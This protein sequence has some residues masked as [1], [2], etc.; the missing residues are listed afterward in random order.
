MSLFV[1]VHSPLC[2][3][4][5]WHSTAQA[6]R[7]LGHDA[8]VLSFTSD[9]TNPAPLWQQQAQIIA[10]QLR[11]LD[12]QQPL[13]W[14]GHS[15][16]GLRLPVYRNAVANPATGYVFVDAGVPYDFPSEGMSQLDAMRRE[17]SGFAEG[18]REFLIN[19]GRFPNW[20][21]EML[22]DDIPNDNVRAM[23]LRELQPQGLRYFD[24]PIPMPAKWPDAPCAYLHFSQSY[25]ADATYAI[26]HQWAHQKIEAGHFQML[27]DPIGTARAIV[28]LK[29][30]I[31]ND[32]QLL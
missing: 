25:N 30:E 8:I 27:I 1:M 2:G 10:E 12:A 18:L 16:A 20:T 14:V 3:P 28:N 23:M 26:D 31:K 11:E 9:E 22:H 24:E 5:T 6:L 4:G 13:I 15:G 21:D 29:S 19:G 7:A 32:I 17:Q